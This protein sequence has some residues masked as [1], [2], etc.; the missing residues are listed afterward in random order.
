[1]L[2]F[3][4]ADQVKREARHVVEWL[5]THNYRVIL[6]STDSKDLCH[7]TAAEVGIPLN[8]VYSDLAFDEKPKLL[9]QINQHEGKILYVC[10]GVNDLKCTTY[11]DVSLAISEGRDGIKAATDIVSLNCTLDDVITSLKLANL[12]NKQMRMTSTLA[13][14]LQC[15]LV[16]FTL[17][18]FIFADF[19]LVPQIICVGVAVIIIIMILVG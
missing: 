11:V 6:T 17:G 7:D 12:I 4:I 9:E 2:D 1:M 18:F 8:C 10:D 14:V 5:Q 19:L 15:V 13:A 3:V 16:P